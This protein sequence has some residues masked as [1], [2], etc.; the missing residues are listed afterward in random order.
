MNN[1]PKKKAA[2]FT[3][4]EVTVAGALM[5]L[6]L[7]VL[8]E[9]LRQSQSVFRV[10][11]GSNDASSQLRKVSQALQRDILQ[12]NY[13]FT[14]TTD[15]TGVP[16][17][18]SALWF[19]SN[20]NP[21]THEPVYM[22]D[23]SPFWQRNILYYLVMP[24]NHVGLFGYSC[25]LAAGPGP[26]SHDDHCA[27]KV[28]IRKEIDFGSATDA[29][30]ESNVEALIPGGSIAAYLTRPAGYSVAAMS[31]EPGVSTVKVVGQLLLGFEAQ[32]A[33]GAIRVD[34]RAVSISRAQREINIANSSLYNSRYTVHFSQTLFPQ[35]K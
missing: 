3:L 32:R 17:E 25:T 24:N 8:A 29:I 6:L 19:L 28:L 9:T 23:G 27:H 22:A 18:G 5:A 31:G 15:S 30:N 35:A 13:T 12:T 16:V 11:S 34:V 33:A 1:R 26:L 7:V 20:L 21:A 14:N 4:L 2:A 10:T